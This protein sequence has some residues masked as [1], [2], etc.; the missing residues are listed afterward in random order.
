VTE[1]IAEPMEAPRREITANDL[2]AT[3]ENRELIGY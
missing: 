2:I 3:T 1:P